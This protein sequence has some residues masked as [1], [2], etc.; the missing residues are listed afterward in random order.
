MI[1]ISVDG[2]SNA[3][4]TTKEVKISGASAIDAIPRMS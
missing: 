3:L 2:D 1:P 4:L